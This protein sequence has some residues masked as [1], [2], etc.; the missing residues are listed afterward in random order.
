MSNF[1]F[2]LE[3]NYSKAVRNTSL[4]T[5]L[6]LRTEEQAKNNTSLLSMKS[7]TT[8]NVDLKKIATSIIFHTTIEMFL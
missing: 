2:Y 1:V 3:S 6:F 5:A 8:K 4:Q 7:K